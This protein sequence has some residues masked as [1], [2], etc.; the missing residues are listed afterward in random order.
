MNIMRA[1]LSSPP[2][3]ADTDTNHQTDWENVRILNY[4]PKTLN[5]WVNPSWSFS[6]SC[7]IKRLI[8]Y[9]VQETKTMLKMVELVSPAEASLQLP[10]MKTADSLLRIYTSRW[11]CKYFARVLDCANIS[12]NISLA[13]VKHCFRTLVNVRSSWKHFSMNTINILADNEPN[14][15]HQ[16]CP[17]KQSN[18]VFFWLRQQPY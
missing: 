13:M 8:L 4:L 14:Q 16:M 12:A 10:V 6:V 17:N 1:A 5:I 15:G 18:I 3:T 9:Y 2:D 11:D 7:S